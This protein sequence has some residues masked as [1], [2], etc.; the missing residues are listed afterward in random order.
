MSVLPENLRNY[1]NQGDPVAAELD[2]SVDGTRCFV[3]IRAHAN[4]AVPREPVRYLNSRYSLWDYWFFEFRRMVLRSGWEVDEW[5]YDRYLV[6]DERLATKSEAEFADALMR[7][8]P[9]PERLRHYWES[10]CPE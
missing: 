8:V 4:P 10:S 3:R 1:L 5:N 6:S 9:D 7:W 2:S